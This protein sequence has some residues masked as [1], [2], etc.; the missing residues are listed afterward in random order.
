MRTVTCDLCG[1]VKPK[2]SVHFC[3]NA[4]MLAWREFVEEHL[5]TAFYAYLRSRMCVRDRYHVER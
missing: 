1:E 3:D 5:E 4:E 2:T